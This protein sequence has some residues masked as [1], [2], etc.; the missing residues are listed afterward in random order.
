MTGPLAARLR[1]GRR[2]PRTLYLQRGVQPAG[3]DEQGAD[4]FT[5]HARTAEI[6][7]QAVDAVNEGRQI[8]GGQW[9]ALGC[10]VYDEPFSVLAQ[11]LFSEWVIAVDSEDL[12]ARIADAANG[13]VSDA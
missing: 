12:A 13:Q 7:Q 1:T 3:A 6:A 8:P 2:N 4:E 9:Y 5:G 11:R 10:L